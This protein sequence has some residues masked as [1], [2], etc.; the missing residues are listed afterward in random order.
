MENWLVPGRY[1]LSP[2]LARLGAG[3]G[4]ALDVRMNLNSITVEGRRDFD[5]LVDMPHTIEIERQP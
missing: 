4:V 1:F 5:G 3:P 2:T